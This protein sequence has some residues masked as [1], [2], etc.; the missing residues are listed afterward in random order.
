MCW[1]HINST[2][3][4]TAMISETISTLFSEEGREMSR[5]LNKNYEHI[6]LP[7]VEVNMLKELE[8]LL[9]ETGAL[10]EGEAIPLVSQDMLPLYE[11][12]I[13]FTI[14]D[15]TVTVLSLRYCG[16]TMLPE[17]LDQLAHL[18][19]LDITGNK[20]STLP[21]SF[22]SLIHLKKFAGDDN[23]LYELPEG[24][25]RL[26]Q[27][28][29]IHLDRNRLT[30][31]PESLSQLARLT[32]LSVYGNAL[33]ALPESLS[34]LSGLKAISIGH[35]RLSELPESFWQLT[36]LEVLNI[37]ENSLLGLSEHIG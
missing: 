19:F 27:L 28:E 4:R 30:T 13:G 10:P 33:T 6:G 16:L 17:A 1:Q 29:E 15:Q 7:T 21:A 20:L 34:Q 35:N 37:A 26:T 8:R 2:I 32:T 9:Q 23:Q 31:L 11:K 36:S 12:G 14:E 25:E 22:A 18:R 3:L 5:A 24:L